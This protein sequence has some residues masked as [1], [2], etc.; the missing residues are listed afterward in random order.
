METHK[1]PSPGEVRTRPVG[2]VEI[3]S[4]RH[5]PDDDAGQPDR[6]QHDRLPRPAQL[7]ADR[8]RRRVSS[9]PRSSRSCQSADENF[10][11][12]DAEVGPDG[13]LY[14][15]D[16]HN[17]IIGHMQ[18]NLRDTSR[19]KEHGR[20]YRV[21]YPGRPLLKPPMIAGE[22]IPRLLDLLKEP[23]NR[24]R[25]RAK[26]ELSARDTRDVIAATEAWMAAPRSEGPAVR[27][28][29]D[30]RRCGCTSGTTASTRRCSRGCCKS[31]DPWA[32]AAATRVLCYWRDRVANPLALLKVL[33]NDPHPARAARGGPGGQLLPDLR[34][35]QGR[36]GV[37]EPSAG[38]LSPVHPRSDDED[39]EEIRELTE[40]VASD[41]WRGE[42][43][44]DGRRV[45][46]RFG[47]GISRVV[48]PYAAGC[49]AGAAAAHPPRRGAAGDR[50]SARAPEQRRADSRRAEGRRPALPSRLLRAAD[51]QGPGA[52]VRRRGARRPG[53]DGRGEPDRRPARSPAP[54]AGRRRRD[55]RQAAAPAARAA[56]RRPA[57]V[58]PGAR[59]RQSRHR[60][61]R[62][63][64]R[65]PT[66]A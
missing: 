46:S 59:H 37:A 42:P 47:R 10:R 44:S 24:V 7:Q 53:E 23:E 61:R 32:R 66:A 31:P 35:R 58:P 29:H 63:C 25:Y 14:V 45:R 21:T 22:P 2:G 64:C 56:R 16:W 9:R 13:A 28:P 8:G 40:G 34:G 33:V 55:G 41:G 12:V 27:A 11:P 52:G 38:S 50:V 48:A 17:P 1:A 43:G 3:L 49:A 62:A 5:F 51:A 54:G 15:A 39:A 30:G 57:R 19:D 36:A 26:I 60:R 65:R 18:H 6:A 4:S 20:I